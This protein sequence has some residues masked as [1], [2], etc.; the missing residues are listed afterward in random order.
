MEQNEDQ[1]SSN[2]EKNYRYFCKQLDEF[3]KDD[4]TRFEDLCLRILESCIVLVVE[5]IGQNEEECLEYALRV[6]HTFN[7]R[8]TPLNDSDIFKSVVFSYRN[9]RERVAFVEQWQELEQKCDVEHLFRLCMHA[10]RARDGE[11]G[12]EI[13]LRPF[14]LKK[15]CNLLKDGSIMQ[16]ITKIQEY[17]YDDKVKSKLS[18]CSNQFYDVLCTLYSKYW[19]FLDGV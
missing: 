5:C 2:Y 19:Q 14:F 6:F 13:A 17:L 7:D 11:K 3:A 18:L 4:P 10:L 16:E 1:D 8:G 12:R 15:H 9:L